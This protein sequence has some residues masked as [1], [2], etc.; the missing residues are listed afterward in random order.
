[1]RVI[2]IGPFAWAPKGTV[3]A[4]AFL[5]A[6]ALVG[7]GHHVTILMPPYDN[8]KHSGYQWQKD[9]VSIF[10]LRLPSFGDSSLARL[11]V[12]VQL[13]R[14]ASGR[15]TDLVHV[16]KPVGY[17]GLAATYLRVFNPR[18]PLVVDCD[19]WEGRAGWAGVKRYAA[20]ERWFAS[21]QERWLSRRAHAV[22]VASRTLE[23]RT[24]DLG[25]SPSRVFYLPNGPHPAYRAYSCSKVERRRVRTQLGIGNAPMGLYIGHITYDSEVDL[26]LDALPAI[27]ARI[28]EFRVVIIGEGEGLNTLKKKAEL[29]DITD[30]LIFTGWVD[31]LRAAALVAS[32]DVTLY[33]YRDVMIN[34]AKSPS[35]VTAYMAMGRPVVASAVGEAVVYLDEGRAGVLVE[36]GNAR[37]LAE[38]VIAVIQNP[39]WSKELGER[40][41]R[42]I[43]EHFDWSSR[44]T[45]IE[46]AYEIAAAA[47]D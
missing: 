11:V 23:A 28:P 31:Q 34:R 15:R 27:I 46:K 37:A 10:N 40:A 39:E 7:R 17:S 44:A 16:F 26:I 33:P 6:R 2:M 13:A 8:P 24:R 38:G 21:W 19:D 41:R 12:P 18:M 5:M 35:K 22:T 30:R 47:V 4:R 20:A 25:V 14:C 43:W 1:M 36:P 3:S 45:T 32:A 42:R 29:C 9:G